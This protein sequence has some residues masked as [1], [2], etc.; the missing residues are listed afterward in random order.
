[1]IESNEITLSVH[2]TEN[3]PREDVSAL[4][5]STTS[6]NKL[7]IFNYVLQAVVSKVLIHFPQTLIA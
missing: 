1:M 3:H 4:V 6:Q 5:V 2:F 7:P